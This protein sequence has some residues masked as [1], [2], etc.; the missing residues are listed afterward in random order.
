MS[1]LKAPQ[2]QRYIEFLRTGSLN[3]QKFQ[4]P[5]QEKVIPAIDE[6]FSLMKRIKPDAN[7]RGKK[8]WLRVPRGTIDDYGSF[9]EANEY[10]DYSSFDEFVDE[11]K[12]FFPDEMM[13]FS[14]S[15]IEDETVRFRAIF[16]NHNLIYEDNGRSGCKFVNID[17]AEFFQW[18]C[19]A[20][21]NC[22]VEL[23]G[24][25]YNSNVNTFLPVEKR[26]GLIPRK[27]YWDIMTEER[28]E[29]LRGFPKSSIEKFF[30]LI[31]DQNAD[32]DSVGRLPTMTAKMF[33]EVCSYGYAANPQEYNVSGMSPKEQYYQFADGR[34]EG[35]SE[36]ESDSTEAFSRWLNGERFMGGHPFEVMRGGN[37]THVSLYVHSD[38]DGYFFVL[39][40][41]SIGRTVET[42][43]FYLALREHNLP[44]FLN[45]SDLFKRRLLETEQIGVV[46]EDVT[47]RYCE[48][49]FPGGNAHDFMQLPWEE[50][51]RSSV[52]AKC[53]W[54]PEPT[55]ELIEA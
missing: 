41:R 4:F 50:P 24:G 36:I 38:E 26:T 19:D 51:E 44:V 28:D 5:D 47:P 1:N 11:W 22:I 2:V 34:D 10:N 43:N 30:E 40:G 14:L 8:L 17:G 32:Y 42:L 29:F 3:G 33:Y 52:A 39:D 35:L 55:V 12:S 37:S 9:E 15:C 53:A 25:T 45:D 49:L 21:R 23:E 16:L 20:V 48:S 7:D 54:L 46:P 31:K 6:L 27:D 13:W 18:L